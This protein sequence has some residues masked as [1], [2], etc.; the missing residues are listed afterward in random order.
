MIV[1][2]AFILG[3]ILLLAVLVLVHEAGHFFVAKAAKV[4]VLEFGIGFPPRLWGVQ[5]GETTYTINAIPLGGFVRM[6][7]EEDPTEPRSLAAQKIHVR[8]LVIVA[9][10]FMNAVMAFLLFAALF[11]VPQDVL[12]GQ[13]SIAQVNPGSPAEQAGIQAGDQVVIVDGNKLDNHGDLSH[14]ISLKV[15]QQMTWQLRRDGRDLTLY[16]TPRLNPPEGQGATGVVV[17]TLNGEA[18]SRA[19]APW[20]AAGHSL[21]TMADVLVITKNEFGKWFAGGKAP[22]VAG[23]I[24]MAQTFT[25]VGETPGFTFKD[26]VLITLNLAAVISLSLAVF[27]I[28][29]LP[30]LD[31]GRL[32]FLL[33]EWVRRG[34]R[35]PPKWEAAIHLGGFAVLMALGVLIAVVDILRIA[36]GGSLLGG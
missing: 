1:T 23:P 17:A 4:K 34:K 14:Y 18:E 19:M 6:V 21:R 25:E 2:I 26:R 13:V 12:V 3:F 35:V 9:G 15:G 20:T 5:K 33:I 8:F 27:N 22:A 24:G 11:M 32:P 29:P 28:L 31:G 36:R 7:G 16:V 30:A 10:A